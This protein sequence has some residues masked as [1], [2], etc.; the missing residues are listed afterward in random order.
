MTSFK[1][2]D[3]KKNLGRSL[4]PFIPLKWRRQVLH[5]GRFGRPVS[6]N[7][8]TFVEKV[9][10]RML[11]DRREIIATTGDKL[12]MKE[13]AMER[14]PEI[15]VPETLWSGEDITEIQTKDWKCDWVLKPREGSGYLAFGSGSLFDSNISVAT[16]NA[17]RHQDLYRV[18][19]AWSYG[20]TVPGYL[21][22]RRIP[23]LNGEPPNDI[24]FYVFDGT[25]RL[26]QVDT[27]RFDQVRRR[28]YTPNWEP[29]DVRQG[30]A[31]LDIAI[32]A[33]PRLG[34]MLSAA[35]RIGV[36]YDFVRVDLYDVAAGIF[37]GEITAYAT[38]G[39]AVFHDPAFEELVGSW[40]NLPSLKEVR[41]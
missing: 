32:D 8:K 1:T 3:I 17:W 6:R 39:M 27:P 41:G 34:E 7:P 20:Q 15:L 24:R 33:P 14:A 18:H 21:L 31:L 4:L 16:V 10:W 12:S 23:T 25:V 13:H 36:G 2:K 19:G 9:N 38:G 29:L 26:I 5:I 28:F 11:H 22:E 40:W 37:F 30:V 35:E